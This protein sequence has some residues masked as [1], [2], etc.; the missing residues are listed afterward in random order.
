MCSYRDVFALHRKSIYNGI[1]GYCNCFGGFAI[2]TSIYADVCT[3]NCVHA[4][5]WQQ[6]AY[7]VIKLVSVELC[8]SLSL[9]LSLS[10]V[11][12]CVCACMRVREQQFEG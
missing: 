3:L 12:V 10:L 8:I 1:H 2:Y 6:Y 9:S 4:I 5:G 11:R 7:D